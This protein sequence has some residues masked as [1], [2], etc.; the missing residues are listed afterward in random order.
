MNRNMN[1]KIINREDRRLASL[2]QTM[3]RLSETIENIVPTSKPRLG[4]GQYLTDKEVSSVMSI[5][6]CRK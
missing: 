3:D 5:I 6:I 2:F 1:S 4:D